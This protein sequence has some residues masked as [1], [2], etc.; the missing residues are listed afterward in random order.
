MGNNKKLIIPE[1]AAMDIRDI[2]M[3]I[4]EQIPYAAGRYVP[5]IQEGLQALKD[6]TDI[7]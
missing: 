3:Y 5:G 2:A 1:E 7:L 6:C 4:K